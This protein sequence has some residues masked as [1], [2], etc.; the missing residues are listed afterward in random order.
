M[1]DKKSDAKIFRDNPKA[2]AAYLAD[3]FEENDIDTVLK[4]INRVMRAQ[5]VQALA[6]E[7]GLRRD[8]LYKT[9]GG[10]TEPY[11]YRVMALLN[12]LGVRL[13]VK[14]MPPR[15]IPP[16][17]KLGRPRKPLSGVIR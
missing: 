8:K 10:D 16:R 2:I 12:A 1:S 9:F 15:P 6:R 17:P 7:A 14:A 3:A 13:T 4:A 5:N 11:L